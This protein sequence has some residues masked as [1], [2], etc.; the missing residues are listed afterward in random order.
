[1]ARDRPRLAVGAVFALARAEQQQGGES[2]GR[3]DQVDRGRAGEVLHAGQAKVVQEEAAGLQ[4]AAA[5]H[6]VGAD[7]VDDRREHDRVGD[8][9]A[10][11]DPLERGAPDDRERHRAERELE[12]PLRLDRGV[13]QAHDAER[14]LRVAEA[15]Q[16]EAVGAHERAV[17]KRER[18]PDRIERDRGDR[19]VGEDLRDPGA[20]VLRAR[21]ADLEQ[22]EACLHEQHEHRRDEHEQRVQR[23]RVAQYPVARCIEGVSRCRDRHE[24][25]DDQRQRREPEG[26]FHRFDLLVVVVRPSYGQPVQGSLASGRIFRAPVSPSGRNRLETTLGGI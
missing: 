13:G 18:E 7:R 2:A 25:R 1:M 4:P 24:Q 22:G 11:L 12:Q 8:V 10:E 3:A 21:E 6:P 5:E 16:Q 14:G 20:R 15:L 19:Q 9:R 26:A 17:A 23:N